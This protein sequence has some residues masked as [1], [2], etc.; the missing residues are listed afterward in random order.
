MLSDTQYLEKLIDAGLDHVQ[1]TIESHDPAIHDEMVR[2]KGAWL[3]TIS[4]LR[5]ALK[6]PLFVMTNT[7]MLK[8][9]SLT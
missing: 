2:A 8:P 6:S 9:N 1:I 4:G 5:N 3:Q 7:T